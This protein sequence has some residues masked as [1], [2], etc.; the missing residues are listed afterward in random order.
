M[1]F[2]VYQVFEI[3]TIFYTYRTLIQMN[4]VSSAQ[5]PRVGRAY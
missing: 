4:W 1:V 5:E 2:L 3:Q